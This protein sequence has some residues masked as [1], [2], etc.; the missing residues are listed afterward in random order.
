MMNTAGRL[1][2]IYVRLTGTSRGNDKGMVHV[3]AEVFDFAPDTPHLEDHVVTCLQAVRSEL[4]LL[5]TKL[6]ALGAPDELMYAGIARFRNI[7]SPVYL[8]QAWGGLRDEISK[9]ENR[10]AFMWAN[11]T[12]R[13]EDE[14]EMPD[15]D[16]AALRD[17]LD[18]LEKALQETDTTP[19]LRDFVQRQL[20]AIRA[21][22]R[23]YR[24]QGVKPIEEALHKVAGAYTIEGTRVEAEYAKSS[25]PTKS[26]LTRATAVIKRTAEVADQLDKIRKF[27]E[28]AYALAARVAPVV[29]AVAQSS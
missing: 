22:L 13:D 2:S 8:N 7:T 6:S 17:E 10:L 26:V 14:G 18:S 4:E 23:V 3:W 28:G 24:V 20:T 5:R 29:M 9:P 1:L 25:E 19:Y 12:L 15:E 11:W 16:L 27:G 21:A